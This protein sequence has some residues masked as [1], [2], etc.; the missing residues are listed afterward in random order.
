MESTVITAD[1]VHGA[2][3]AAHH[4]PVAAGLTHQFNESENDLICGLA[5]RMHV[6]GLFTLGIGL[7]VIMIGTITINVPS[8]LSGTLY[9][10]IGLWTDRASES[11]KK[12]SDT[13]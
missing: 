7:F 10:V 9:S 6:V 5:S 11:F 8:I 2:E 4:G 3:A 13:R 1:R 12:I